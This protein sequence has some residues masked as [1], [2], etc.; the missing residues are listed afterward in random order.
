MN[1]L[2]CTSVV[3]FKMKLCSD[4][5]IQDSTEAAVQRRKEFEF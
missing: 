4:Q 2:H 3:F 1:I 5:M